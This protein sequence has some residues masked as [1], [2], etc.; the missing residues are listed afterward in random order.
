M[1]FPLS[2]T[3]PFGMFLGPTKLMSLPPSLRG[4]LISLIHKKGDR[5]ECKNWRPISLL[6][7]DY[8]LCARALAG[9][10]LRVLHYVINPDQTC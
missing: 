3:V 8:K 7:A 9:R 1:A 5:L 4:A 10:L 2:F 6:S